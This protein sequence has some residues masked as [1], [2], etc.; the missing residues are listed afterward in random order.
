MISIDDPSRAYAKL[1]PAPI[2][3]FGSAPIIVEDM[4]QWLNIDVPAYVL[5]TA[6]FSEPKF[7]LDIIQSLQFNVP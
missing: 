5:N 4:L 1:T 2:L 6:P 7:A 3:V